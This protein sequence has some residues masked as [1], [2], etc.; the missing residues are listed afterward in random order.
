MICS[1]K[2]RATRRCS[3]WGWG[4]SIRTF[5][6]IGND[7]ESPEALNEKI[8]VAS[9]IISPLR[10]CSCSF[11]FSL[12]LNFEIENQLFLLPKKWVILETVELLNLRQSC[13]VLIR[14]HG[15]LKGPELALFPTTN[16]LLIQFWQLSKLSRDISESF[17]FII[18]FSSY[19][20]SLNHSVGK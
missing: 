9:E 7:H 3:E 14:R 2:L 1:C 5:S 11:C 6:R 8:E 12:M 15:S 17:V 20:T 18:Y 4:K 13:S 16:S 10:T 19:N